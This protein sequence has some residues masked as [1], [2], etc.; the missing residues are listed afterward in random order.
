MGSKA[1]PFSCPIPLPLLLSI[2]TEVRNTKRI[3]PFLPLTW[4][5]KTR[6]LLWRLMQDV[7]PC[8][9]LCGTELA[10]DSFALK[11]NRWRKWSDLMPVSLY[12]SVLT[13]PFVPRLAEGKHARGFNVPAAWNNLCKCLMT[14]A[15]D[16]RQRQEAWEA[17]FSRRSHTLNSHA[18]QECHLLSVTEKHLCPNVAN[19]FS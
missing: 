15:N 5:G 2:G 1:K 18:S 7:F 14:C 6:G 17:G 16:V 3:L 19:C 8:E 9:M 13:Q 12:I 10:K 11:E 4:S